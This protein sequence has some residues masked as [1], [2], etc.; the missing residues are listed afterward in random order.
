MVEALTLL[1]H[2]EG[3]GLPVA[4]TSRWV[5]YLA[6]VSPSSVN[7]W[8]RDCQRRGLLE[9]GPLHKPARGR[10]AVTW[11]PLWPVVWVGGLPEPHWPGLERWETARLSHRPDPSREGFS[12][13]APRQ[14]I[15][16]S[17]L[18]TTPLRMLAVEAGLEALE[19]LVDY[20]RWGLLSDCLWWLMV[21]SHLHGL[22]PDHQVVA[23]Q[24]ADWLAGG[25]S[26]GQLSTLL[27]V[28]E[29]APTLSPVWTAADKG[30]M[31]RIVCLWLGGLVRMES[32]EKWT[33]AS[34]LAQDLQDLLDG[35]E[36]DEGAHQDV[37]EGLRRA[38]GG[39]SHLE[40]PPIHLLLVCPGSGDPFQMV[41]RMVRDLLAEGLPSVLIPALVRQVSACWEWVG[42]PTPSITSI[43]L[44]NLGTGAWRGEWTLGGEDGQSSRWVFAL[45]DRPTSPVRFPVSIQG[46]PSPFSP[47]LAR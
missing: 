34:G 13:L 7:R 43:S 20:P 14:S 5:A 27:Q 4:A 28:L 42:Y 35:E 15:R 29:V 46:V 19:A 21:G 40:G 41:S 16:E 31:A 3:C 33:Q 24:V 2:L 44:S 1:T 8:A 22:P 39:V 30:L 17:I 18:R 38:W 25:L 23:S 10:E 37:R 47:Y 11:R 26:L 45:S 32:L 12:D 6:G 36:M 9:S